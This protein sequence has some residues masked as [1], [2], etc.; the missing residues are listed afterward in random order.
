MWRPDC[1]SKYVRYGQGVPQ[2]E[3]LIVYQ[4][5]DGMAKVC[6]CVEA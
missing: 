5:M 1:I 3:D 4:S 6:L 2:C